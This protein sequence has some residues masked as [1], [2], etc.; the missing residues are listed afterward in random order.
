MTR[1]EVL[2]SIFMFA[3]LI[4]AVLAGP[5]TFGR[6]TGHDQAVNQIESAYLTHEWDKGTT[7]DQAESE[8]EQIM[9]R[10]GE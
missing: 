2:L 5:Y 8:W 6:A 9:E 4:V 3:V 1:D 7:Q 10:M